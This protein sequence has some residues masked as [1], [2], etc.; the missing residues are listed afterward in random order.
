MH[1][2]VST[3][4]PDTAYPW[5]I[6]LDNIGGDGPGTAEAAEAR[7]SELLQLRE[8]VPAELLMEAAI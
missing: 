7:F 2:G 3:A 5:S 4:L 6:R 1:D 8:I